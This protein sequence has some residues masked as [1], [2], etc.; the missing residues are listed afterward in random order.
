[1]HFNQAKSLLMSNHVLIHFNPE[2]DLILSCDGSAY[3]VGA[4]LSHRLPNISERPIAFASRTLSSS[5]KDYSQIEKETLACVFGVKQFHLYVFGPK[6]TLVTD[7]KP[8]LTLLNES[9][10]IPTTIS[11]QI[12]RWALTLA[13]YNYSILFKFLSAHANTDA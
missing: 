1:M 11:N 3:G 9:R 5:E 13:M 8:L 2:K 10:G 12:Q 4:M 6:F 7:H